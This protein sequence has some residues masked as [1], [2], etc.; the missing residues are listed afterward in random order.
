MTALVADRG[1][2][3]EVLLASFRHQIGVR[4]F[5][6]APDIP[7]IVLVGLDHELVGSEAVQLVDEAAAVNGSIF[8]L[9]Y[10]AITPDVVSACRSANLSLMAWTVDKAENM[11][12]MV[13]VGVDMLASNDLDLLLRTLAEV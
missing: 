11:M 12:D 2:D 7:F 3:T 6:L 1:M 4:L 8:G 5:E 9:N 10:T 13:K